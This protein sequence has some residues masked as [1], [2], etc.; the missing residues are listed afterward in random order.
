MVIICT[1]FRVVFRLFRADLPAWSGLAPIRANS[2]LFPCFRKQTMSPNHIQFLHHRNPRSFQPYAFENPSA[3]SERGMTSVFLRLEKQ[4]WL[5]YF[6]TS[7]PA[8]KQS[9]SADPPKQILGFLAVVVC[10]TSRVQ[11]TC[12]T[13]RQYSPNSGFKK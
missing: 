11:E 5:D 8:S 2:P 13:M 10:C 3:V 1:F 6:R 4:T 7:I 9:E 12:C